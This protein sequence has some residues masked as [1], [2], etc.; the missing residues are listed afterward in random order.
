MK[1][2]SLLVFSL[3]L[4]LAASVFAGVEVPVPVSAAVL[5]FASTSVLVEACL[6][7]KGPVGV[8]AQ[9]LLCLPF[10]HLLPY[11]FDSPP[12][13]ALVLWGLAANPYMFESSVISLTSSIGAVAA[14]GMASGLLWIDI[15][16]SQNAAFELR[17]KVSIWPDS[18][19]PVWG[20]ILVIT[21]ALFMAQLSAPTQTIFTASYTGEAST[22]EKVRFD[23]AW[24]FA[25]IILLFAL[26]D[27]FFTESR[28]KAFI[29]LLACI[30]A[31]LYFIVWL[32]FAR[33]NR[34]AISFVVAFGFITWTWGAP[35]L[36]VSKL[37]YRCIRT[38]AV[39]GV[40]STLLSG[41]ALQKLR[42]QLAPNSESLPQLPE[43]RLPSNPESMPADES[44]GKNSSAGES[45]VKVEGSSPAELLPAPPE[46]LKDLS[47]ETPGTLFKKIDL[48][49]PSGTWS[50]VLLTPLSVAGDVLAG[51][52]PKRFGR[53][54]VELFLS[55][56][57]GF[58]ANS[59]GYN[60]P[61]DGQRG[62]AHEM[63]YGLGGTHASVVPMINFGIFGV[64][65]ILFVEGFLLALSERVTGR[66]GIGSI[67]LQGT[68]ITVLPHWLWY[69][70]KALLT[71]LSIWLFIFALYKLFCLRVKTTRPLTVI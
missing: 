26:A 43:D 56:P 4:G 32:Q 71:G 3:G 15:N 47:A 21:I 58:I 40:V 48:K 5:V 67:I 37:S 70:E 13:G 14:C 27:A 38:A 42:Y 66:A 6:L 22:A 57:P 39:L 24:L 34:E 36:A 49:I 46:S 1:T 16:R 23:S 17:K 30:S 61:I 50:A 11:V 28:P 2:L 69:G 51:K 25:C 54:Y 60:R 59:L 31:S 62:P 41:V 45:P 20:A 53:T 10:V 52:L 64:L 63:R 19:L 35:Q 65:L 68:L 8:M 29:K 44:I 7:R 55:M 9:L 33:G 12:P 18:S